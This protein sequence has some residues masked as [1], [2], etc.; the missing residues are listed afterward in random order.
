MT[1]RLR[2]VLIGGL[3]ALLLLA[4]GLTSFLAAA[5]WKDQLDQ[6]RD[7]FLAATSVERLRGAYSDQ[8][9][10][11]RGYALTGTEDFLEPYESGTANAA[12]ALTALDGVAARF[13]DVGDAR[14]AV[15]EAAGRWRAEAAVPEI[16]ALQQGRTGTGDDVQSRDLFEAVRTRT[17]DLG[18]RI[19]AHLTAARQAAERASHLVFAV[20]AVSVGVSIVA[21]AL[22]ALLLRRWVTRPLDHLTTAIGDLRQGEV[23]AIP[24]EGPPEVRAVGRAIDGLQREVRSQ[25]DR[26]VH[27]REA[28]EQSA[29]LAVQVNASLAAQL[30][31]YPDGWTVAAALRPA[32]GL[33]AGDCYDVSLV[34][35]HH[36]GLVVL[37]IAG[38][39]A[40]SAIT[41]LRCKELVKAALR[42][43]VA[44]G[45][46]LAWLARQDHGIEA[47]SFL[48]AVV[49]DID[50]RTGTCRYANAGHP[51]PPIVGD[52]RRTLRPTGPL[53]G[54]FAASWGTAT[55]VVE[56]GEKLVVYTDGLTEARDN[57]RGFYGEE[58]VVEVIA[59][60]AC[61][62]AQAVVKV[63]LDDLDAFTTGRA[64]DDV[65]LIVVCRTDDGE[66]RVRRDARD[67]RA[68]D[69]A[70]G[71]DDA[72]AEP[73]VSA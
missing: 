61:A 57:A 42:S 47:G 70:G 3:V 15:E 36:I 43:G 20:L 33:A 25:R 24:V 62:D 45:D 2:L 22:V 38:H 1:L 11:V 50:T 69:D 54:P 41:A 32:E 7:L 19:D 31:D 30:G 55:E 68:D 23:V 12:D 6:R 60:A 35:P 48:T 51:P 40:E 72:G 46:T 13:A 28:L 56:P 67:E 52:V 58:R 49:A 65:T 10:G 18:G 73:R 71:G 44:P 37:D 64:R 29:T 39:G 4:A 16:D 17:T 9:T 59:D 5:H 63:L 53:F 21:T 14:A 27:A 8:E 26:A 66:P 34:S